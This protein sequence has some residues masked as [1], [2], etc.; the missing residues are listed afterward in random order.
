MLTHGQFSSAVVTNLFGLE[1]PDDSSMISY[2]PL[3]HIYEVL[4]HDLILQIVF[5]NHRIQRVNEM[6]SFA[7]GTKIGFFS[8]D[9]LRL[10]EDCQILKPMFFPG[11]P[12]VL[13][14]IY[15]AAMA[16]G[17]VP[18]FKGNLFRKAVQ[19][20]V[21]KWHATGDNTHFFW[22][23]LVFRKVGTN[24]VCH[25]VGLPDPHN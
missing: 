18:G 19:V 20:K 2:L 6:A 24:A 7:A 10:L 25:S 1:L 9:P 23:K 3:A 21:E 16:A 12:R 4:I 11:V 5:A 14:R 22:D 15:Q 13:N 17:D 8:G